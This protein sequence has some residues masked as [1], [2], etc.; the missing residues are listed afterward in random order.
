MGSPNQPFYP[1]PLPLGAAWHTTRDDAIGYAKFTA[2]HI[3]VRV[4]PQIFR[5]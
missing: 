5:N 3:S 4:I 2:D 1:D